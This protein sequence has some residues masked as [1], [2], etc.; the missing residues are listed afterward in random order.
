MLFSKAREVLMVKMN[1]TVGGE[2]F[3]DWTIKKEEELLY[4][5]SQIHCKSD[6][7]IMQIRYLRYDS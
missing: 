3:K 4:G 1:S 5:L 2:V 7:Y 6:I